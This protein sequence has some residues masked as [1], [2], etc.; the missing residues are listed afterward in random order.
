MKTAAGWTKYAICSTVLFLLVGIPS[1][2]LAQNSRGTILGHV[3]DS[4]GAAVQNAAVTVRNVSTGVSNHFTSNSAGDFVFVDLIPG[5]YDLTVDGKGF[6]IEHASG[7]ILE[8]DQTLRQDFTLTVGNVHEE[9]TV[10]ADT[11]MVQ[12]DNTTTGNVLDQ[13]TIEELPSSGRD[14]TNLLNLNAGASNPS[15]GDLTTGNVLHGLN[16][17]FTEVSLNGARPDSNSYMVDGVNDNDT[18]FSSASNVPSE[19]SLQE[20]KIQDGLY[21]AEYG[22]GSGQVNVAIKSGTNQWHGQAY[23]FFQNDALQ[24]KSPLYVYDNAVM[25]GSA[26]AS[27]K[28]ILKQNQFGGTLGGPVRI[29]WLY[30][31][32]DKTFWF[33]AY[34]GGREVATSG[35][36]QNAIQVPSL[37]ERTGDF[38]ELLSAPTPIVIYNPATAQCSGG[39][40]NPGT[41]LP[42]TNNM[43]SG[44]LNTIGQA[45]VNLYP[46]PNVNCTFPCNN[47]LNLIHSSIDTDNITMRVDQNFGQRDR[48]YFTGHIR[49]DDEP[50]PSNLPDTG[51]VAFTNS[52]LYGI[53]WDHTFNG[54]IINEA[55]FGYNHQYYHSG[56]DTAF[57]PNLSAQLGLMNAPSNPALFGIPQMSLD[58]SYSNIGNNSPGLSTKHSVFQ[59]VDNLKLTHNR[60]TLSMGTD[61]R[62]YRDFESD[63]YGA[64]GTLS[65]SGAYTSNT[66][67]GGKGTG[68]PIA[69]ILL[70]DPIGAGPPAPL[71]TDLLQVR[72]TS[73]SFFF[74]DDFR[75]TDRLTL[76]LG[77]RYEL[78]PAFHSIDGGGFTLNPA[79]GGSLE[80]VNSSL[81]QSLTIPGTNPHLLSCCAQASLVP[82]DTK[83]FAPR[84][85]LAWRPFP[86]NRMVVRAGYGIFY[87]IYERYYDIVQNF[88]SPSVFALTPNPNYPSAAGTEQVSPLLL[89]GLW[90]PPVG[91]SQ[92]FTLPS[93]SP[94]LAAEGTGIFNQVVYPGNHTPYN[95]QWTLDTQYALKP[96]LLLDIGYVGSHDLRLPTQLLLNAAR[97][98]AVPSDPC[99]QVPYYDASQAPASCLSDPN[100]SPVDAR[101]PYPGLPSVVYANA[102]VLSGNYNAL[103]TQ[104][105]Q[106]FS[107]GL[108]YQVFYT[109]SK[110]LDES[111]G[112][113]NLNGLSQ[114]IQDPHNVQDDYGPASFDQKHRLTANATW[115]LPVGKGKPWSLGWADWIVGGWKMSGIY[116]LTSGPTYSIYA[117]NNFQFTDETGS[118]FA[119]RYRANQVSNPNSGFTRSNTNWFNA[120]AFV[121]PPL[122]TYGDEQKGSLRGPYVEDLDLSFGKQFSITERQRLQ[123]RLEIFNVGS[124]WHSVSRVPSNDMQNNNFGSLV[125]ANSTCSG[126]PPVCSLTNSNWAHLNLWTPRVLQMS[127]VYSF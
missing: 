21:S 101:V 82:R 18:F 52:D 118:P 25:P 86:T 57:G 32:H 119:G 12:T 14:F 4:T 20:V 50:N 41:R 99:N 42:F 105:R 6:K 71:G 116:R 5:T 121:A 122:G 96:D 27:L 38:S 94:N 8:V 62:R 22:Q 85:G 98:P 76:N 35:F 81:V 36:S 72:G 23:D 80:F 95:Q 103:Q 79:N 117:F 115:E 114:F 10:S 111:S 69:D 88:D 29:P 58:E 77:L 127:L 46:K 53:D 123:Y 19:F 24:P 15:G 75:V 67:T 17:S 9:V 28:P 108:T 104:L 26:P 55:R 107:H 63:A 74:Q 40:C 2:M 44:P 97:Q 7:L 64:L 124:N 109:Y 106:R 92:F 84:I 13:R 60:H 48:M 31:G 90:L 78:P 110:A 59:W 100:F 91:T 34:D 39:V 89:N 65:F 33:F 11:Q 1:S 47:Y 54:N 120:N 3:K 66:G 112:I 61:I 16:K 102:N 113:V 30:D 49:H 45:I 93:W 68:D 126:T 70:G 73:F 37:K 43:I 51:S 87:E 56:A 83:D 125:P